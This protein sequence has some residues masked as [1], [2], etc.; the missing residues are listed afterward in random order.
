MMVPH[1]VI[2]EWFNRGAGL[3]PPTEPFGGDKKRR[4]PLE[5]TPAKAGAGMTRQV[6][7]FL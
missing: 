3:G 2:P 6:E 5:F 7:E 4:F 1:H